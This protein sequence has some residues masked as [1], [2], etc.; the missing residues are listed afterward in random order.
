MRRNFYFVDTKMALKYK[1]DATDPLTFRIILAPTTSIV[2]KIPRITY[3]LPGC[4]PTR[5][6]ELT[7]YA[8][9]NIIPVS[10]L[11]EKT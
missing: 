5:D 3:N 9:N 10:R 2:R 4:G 1:G 8:T 7:P 11:Q 6:P